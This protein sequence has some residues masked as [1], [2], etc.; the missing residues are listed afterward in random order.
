[1]SNTSE[2]LAAFVKQYGEERIVH[3][4][5]QRIENDAYRKRYNA[6]KNE[7]NREVNRDPR[8]RALKEAAKR[9][10]EAKLKQA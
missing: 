8:L 6:V 10:V 9:R 5:E 2:R 7:V 3:W 4:I 1:V